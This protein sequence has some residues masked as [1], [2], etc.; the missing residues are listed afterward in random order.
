MTDDRCEDDSTAGEL[1]AFSS[2]ISA[3]QGLIYLRY[4][5]LK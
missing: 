4:R 5:Y 2:Q 1:V 3:L